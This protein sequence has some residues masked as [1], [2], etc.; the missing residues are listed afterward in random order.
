MG[1]ERIDRRL[2]PE[3]GTD[4]GRARRVRP[5]VA[6]ADLLAVHADVEVDLAGTRTGA[7]VG[8]GR[9]PGSED[10]VDLPRL[11]GPLAVLNRIRL[12]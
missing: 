1:A 5:E 11:L 12:R 9:F 2:G 7:V 3:A 8:E 10:H 4:L 6:A